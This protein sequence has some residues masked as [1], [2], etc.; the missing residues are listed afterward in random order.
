MDRPVP[1]DRYVLRGRVVHVGCSTAVAETPL[2]DVDE[3]L[4][5]IPD[6]LL[7]SRLES[8]WLIVGV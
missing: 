5:A 1:C 6:Q 4:C 7:D 2:H 8:L 3:R